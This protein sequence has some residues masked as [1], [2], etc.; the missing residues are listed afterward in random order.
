M[1]IIS[2]IF[3]V[4]LIAT[5]V[6]ALEVGQ[7]LAGFK[8]ENQFEESMELNTETQWLL[9]SKDMKPAKVL[10]EYLNKNKMDLGASKILIVSDVSKMPAFVSKMFAI[11]KMKKY[12]F[13]MGLDKTGELSK[14]WPAKETA[15]TAIKLSN[16]KIESIEYLSTVE[17]MNSFF[18]KNAVKIP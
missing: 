7:N 9:F 11:P 1:K 13:K 4:L 14:D 17:E 15:V 6:F 18:I 2:Q 16:F 5:P 3:A 8:V 12:S 10:A